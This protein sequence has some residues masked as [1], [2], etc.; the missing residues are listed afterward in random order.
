MKDN[1]SGYSLSFDTLITYAIGFVS[2]LVVSCMIAFCL[3]AFYLFTL[4][5]K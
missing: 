3:G 1:D 2:F 5:T 4:A